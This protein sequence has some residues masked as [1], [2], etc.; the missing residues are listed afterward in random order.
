MFVYLVFFWFLILYLAAYN[1][2]KHEDLFNPLKFISLFYI[3]RNIP[4]LF[5]LALDNSIF[6][7]NILR[8]LHMDLDGALIN[9]MIFQTLAF[10]SL[11][12]G[13]RFN[14]K[15]IASFPYNYDKRDYRLFFIVLVFLIGFSGFLYFIY[16]I[17]GIFA[18]LE[19]LDNRVGLQSG[20]Y[21]LLLIPLMS[22]AC[23]FL[24]KKYSLNKRNKLL[25]LLLIIIVSITIV[26]NSSLGGRKS[27]L[28]LIFFLLAAYNYYISPI[29]FKKI[30]FLRYFVLIG[31]VMV[32]IF[33][34]PILRK[35]G[36]WESF[37][38]GEVTMEDFGIVEIVSQISYLSIDVF[39]VNYFT[40]DNLWDFKTL[41]TIPMNF[42][43]ANKD[44]NPPIDEGVYYY[45]IINYFNP[46]IA[47]PTPKN[48]LVLVSL[49]IE[50]MGFAF[51]NFHFL[52][53]IVFYFFL[54]RIYTFFYKLMLKNKQSEAFM[55]MYVYVILNFNFSSLRLFNFFTTLALMSFFFFYTRNRISKS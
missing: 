27:T 25:L 51:G 33:L 8:A 18:L 52:G 16:S 44:L 1:W 12:I 10:V 13:I 21:I 11:I 46:T 40:L 7:Q 19:N 30:S 41:L 4:Y 50:Q 3:I 34:I 5:F 17:G 31:L 42:L 45:N 36:G 32:Y 14:S 24:L 26:S 43:G 38:K 55:F 6:P 2:S 20:A 47:P 54:G 15:N 22:L 49:P 35:T 39:T 37:T 9:Y 53:I 48:E 23:I 28:F 29:N